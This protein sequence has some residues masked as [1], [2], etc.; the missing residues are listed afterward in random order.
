[1]HRKIEKAKK[2]AENIRNGDEILADEINY[3]KVIYVDHLYGGPE[4]F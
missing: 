4:I 2:P 1:M 3:Y